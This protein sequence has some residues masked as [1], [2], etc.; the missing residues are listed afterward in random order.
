MATAIAQAPKAQ[1][2]AQQNWILSPGWDMVYFIATPILALVAV[3]L[4]YP[5]LGLVW[6]SALFM[7][8]TIAHHFPTFLRIYGDRDLFR[9]YR[10]NF[11][12]G[13]VLPFGF[14]MVVVACV[15]ATH[16]GPGFP[17]EKV[18]YLMFVPTVWD[19][20]HFLMQHY[21]FVRIYD[22]PNRVPRKVAS[23]MDLAICA[24]WF[25]AIMIK[26]GGWLPWL[27][28]G[29]TRDMSIPVLYW[30]NE[31]S[32]R[33][34][35]HAVFASAIAATVLY[36]VYLAWCRAQGYFVSRAKL[37]LLGITFGIMYL[38][39]VP[40]P[41]MDRLVAWWNGVLGSTQLGSRTVPL[42]WNFWLG[43][44]VMGL[45]HNTQ[46]FAIVWKY[47]RSLT[48][49]ADPT[50]PAMF[51]RAFVRGG[52]AVLAGYVVLCLAYGAVLGGVK[53]LAGAGLPWIW[54]TLFALGFTSTLMH[55]YFDGFIWKVRHRENREHLAMLE[56][57]DADRDGAT[58]DQQEALPSWWDRW[59]G[60]LKHPVL[61]VAW[62]HALYFGLPLGVLTAG[63][64]WAHE[65]HRNE[66]QF[67]VVQHVGVA[68]EL[69]RMGRFDEAAERIGAATALLD[70]SIEEQRRLLKIS[71]LAGNYA[72]L[73]ELIYEQA[74]GRAE[75][76]ARRTVL[77]S[78]PLRAAK[79]QRE[80]GRLFQRM[81]QEQSPGI[82]AREV[83]KAIATL[84]KALASRGPLNDSPIKMTP[85]QGRAGAYK[86]L[87]EWY[88][89]I[90]ADEQAQQ[91]M[92]LA[93][94]G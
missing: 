29:L 46:Y 74:R 41:V 7:V 37:L 65:S 89:E 82:F 20:W 25:T 92:A 21:G 2:Q 19:A 10:W 11:L 35:E 15:I 45:V 13:P 36:L 81:V 47:N 80:I 87:A 34:L 8:Y 78:E 63:A 70:G 90:G 27:L 58:D 84:E 76:E 85:E 14:A 18:L 30:V 40:N 28:A 56:A 9:R 77:E 94:G 83:R 88:R 67:R 68:D 69:V 48:R 23:R 64:W 93:A 12:L 61:R 54:G 39:Y 75:L 24:T 26:A 57:A 43:F 73:A 31:S 59:R 86:Q 4:L 79:G 52:L 50:R 44:V 91:A 6:L 60:G 16:R 22:G 38:T 42:R 53:D 49:K 71:P 33:L 62:R 5:L 1:V 51:Q 17:M 32:Y 55:Y 66:P 3:A 72:G